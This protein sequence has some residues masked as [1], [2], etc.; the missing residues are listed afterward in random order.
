MGSEFAAAG[1]TD[2]FAEGEITP[3]DIGG[4]EVAVVR[5]GDRFYAFDN[6][7]PHWGVSLSEGWVDAARRV[8]C[9]YHDSSFDLETGRTTGGPALDDLPVYAVKVEGGQVFIKV[10][11]LD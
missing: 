11:S 5:M 3:V 2:A 4:A 6:Q 1:P 7:C 9:A 8:V 10:G